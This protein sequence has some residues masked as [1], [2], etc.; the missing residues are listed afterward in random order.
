MDPNKAP[1]HLDHINLDELSAII[2][3]HVHNDHTGR[4]AEIVEAGYRGPIYMTPM[5]LSLLSPILNDALK[6]QRSNIETIKE[7][8]KKL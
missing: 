1:N 7:I 6:I 5:S 2:L 4:L 8:N 3:T